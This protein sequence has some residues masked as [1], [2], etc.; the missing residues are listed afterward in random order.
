MNHV[1]LHHRRIPRVALSWAL[2]LLL[3]SAPGA[4]AETLVRIRVVG[5]S[6]V[7]PEQVL[8]WSGLEAGQEITQE[9]VSAAVRKLANS[10]KFSEVFAYR[11]PTQGGMELI[12]NL[13]EY[14]RLAG[15]E[16]AGTDHLKKKDLQEEVDLRVGDFLSPGAVT[17]TLFK[18]REKYQSEGYYNAQVS[19]DTTAFAA[20]GRQ[21]LVIRVK[22]GQK[23]K[24]HDIRFVGNENV[25]EDDLRKGW[26]T[27]ED[28]FLRLSLI[29]I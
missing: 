24:V 18:V 22:E 28:G 25:S 2:L 27:K 3:L 17:R 13:S 5:I 14:P 26:E 12:L 29:H 9:G 20:G 4:S 11:V 7:Q 21:T 1:S 15:V 6:T 16:F 19:T 23:I 10:G 8:G